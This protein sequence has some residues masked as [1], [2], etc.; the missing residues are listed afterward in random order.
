[1]NY[2]FGSSSSDNEDETQTPKPGHKPVDLKDTRL[3]V[4][5]G[6]SLSSLS[7]YNVNDDSHPHFI[8]SPF[9]TGNMVVRIKN[10]NGITPDPKTME[11]IPDSKYFGTRKRLFSVQLQGRFKH[12]SDIEITCI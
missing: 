12:V 6:P 7:T 4:R 5:I 2:F 9:F 8:D 11:P 3:R 10:F 1:M